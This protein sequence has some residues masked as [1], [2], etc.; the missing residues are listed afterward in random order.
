MSVNST[1]ITAVGRLVTGIQT[2]VL[3]DT[4]VKVANFRMACQERVYDKDRDMWVDGDRMYMGVACWR[5]LADNVADSLV[6][7]DQVVVRGRLKIREYKTKEGVRRTAVEVDAWAVGPDLSLYTVAIN[8]RDWRTSANQQSLLT[9][10]PTDD[11]LERE[12][13][14][15]AA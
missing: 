13:V 15:Q 4:G 14:T 8:R 5:G 2:H 11:P 10:P 1:P 12:E 7:G 9:P 3:P 6:E